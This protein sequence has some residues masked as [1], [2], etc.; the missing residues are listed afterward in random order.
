MSEASK[1]GTRKFPRPGFSRVSA[2]GATTSPEPYA[3]RPLQTD[4]LLYAGRPGDGGVERMLVNTAYGLAERGLSVVFVTRGSKRPFLDQL[5][6]SVRH[7]VL[8]GDQPDRGLVDLLIAE[9][10]LVAISGKIDDDQSLMAARE[11]AGTGTEIYFRVGNPL[12]F[13]LRAKSR[14]PWTKWWKRRQLTRLYQ[15]PDG[16]VAVSHGISSDLRI[17]LNVRPDRIRVLPNPVVTPSLL[18]H[19]RAVPEHDW[20]GE[21]EPP[22]VVAVGGL[23]QQ[24]DFSTLIRAFARLRRQYQCRLVIIGEGRQMNRLQSLV[25]ELG[26]VADVDFP[27]WTSNPYPWIRSATVLA[28]SSLWE[29]FGNVIV[30]ALALGT[31]VVATDCPY[32]PGEI[33][34][35]GVYGCLVPVRDDAAMARALAETMNDLPSATELW[36]GAAPYTLSAS[37]AAYAHALGLES[38]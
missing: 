34:Q 26:V 8:P 5:G 30:E 19:G 1:S 2:A 10:P 17:E 25:R 23:R 14:T 38:E 22:V 4:L 29:G 7:V 3:R 15:R 33:L 31:P 6:S 32:G 24:K 35:Q 36:E 20:F 13:R 9:K 28:L 21:N 11:R 18:E 16:F 27:G 37:A 12:G